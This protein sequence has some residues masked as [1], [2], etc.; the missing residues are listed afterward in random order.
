M[1]QYGAAG[2]QTQTQIDAMKTVL[3]EVFRD[4][5]GAGVLPTSE[6][7]VEEGKVATAETIADVGGGE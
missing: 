1:D 7:R 3:A 2:Q 4:L 5:Q 6:Q